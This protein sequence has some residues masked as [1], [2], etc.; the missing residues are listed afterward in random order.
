[1]PAGQDFGSIPVGG[2]ITTKSAI[3]PAAHSADIACSMCATFFSTKEDVKTLLNHLGNSTV[4]GP[5]AR[6]PGT[7]IH[8]PVLE[9]EIWDNPFLKD[10]QPIASRYLGTQ[11]DGNHFGYIGEIEVSPS[12]IKKL[13]QEGY[14][15]HVAE[16]QPF[17]GHTLQ[18]LVTHHG[19]RNLG[20][21]LY[22]RGMK[23]AEYET[24]KI[25]TGI[26]KNGYWLD[27]NTEKGKNYWEALQYIG[28]WTIAN[29]EVIHNTF[30]AEAGVK[31]IGRIKNDHNYIWEKDGS[32][33]HGKGATPAWRDEQGRAK[34][35]IIPLN[36][37]RE[38][39][40]VLGRD[41]TQFLS[42]APHGAGRNQSRTATLKPYLDPKTGKPDP[43]KVAE[44]L[45]Q[46]TQGVEVRWGSGKPDISESPFGYKDASKNYPAVRK[47]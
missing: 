30:L 15:N 31:A 44:A 10:L 4:F 36:M 42:F 16:L 2:A 9:E 28:R 19:S 18:T 6:R 7:E 40:L 38:I 5:F 11:G 17:V 23:A 34:L 13:E 32:F 37:G 43:K 1:M 33:Y 35:G 41:N 46:A 21:Q 27:V 14:Y 47:V 45:A 8:H 22:K 29:H 3:L 20:A 39:L 12:L 25:A 26:P 24:N